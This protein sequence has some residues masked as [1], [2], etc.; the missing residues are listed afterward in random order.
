MSKIYR[1]LQERGTLDIALAYARVKSDNPTAGALLRFHKRVAR[2]LSLPE[3]PNFK[4]YF[5]TGI[6]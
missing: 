5:G 6:N 2:L 1:E 4:G 3:W